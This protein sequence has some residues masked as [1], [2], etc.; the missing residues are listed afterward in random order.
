V[1]QIDP[2]WE[3][4]DI[5]PRTIELFCEAIGLAKTV[6]WNGPLGVF[7]LAPFANGTKAVAELLASRD[8]IVSVIG[9]GDTAAAVTQFGLAERM[10]HVSTGGG[11]SLE[12]LEGKELPGIVSLTDK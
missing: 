8:D 6:V 7:E 4:L 10:S 9:G 12:M 5:G 2:E 11:A 1:G 3:G